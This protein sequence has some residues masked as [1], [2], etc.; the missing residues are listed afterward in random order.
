MSF[1]ISSEKVIIGPGP[2]PIQL[3]QSYKYNDE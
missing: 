3:E 1:Y 2:N